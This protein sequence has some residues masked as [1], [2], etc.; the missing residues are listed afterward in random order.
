[1][2]NRRRRERDRKSE[3]Q[4]SKGVQRL[5]TVVR[6]LLILV[7]VT[8]LAVSSGTIYPFAVGK[9]VYAHALI[10]MA[11]ACWLVLVLVAPT[12]RPRRAWVFAA[13]LVWLCVSVLAAY[14]G[15]SPSRSLWSTYNRMGG[16]VDLAHWC[17][18]AV[19]I[20]SVFRTREHWKQLLFAS[21]LVSAVVSAIGILAN[22]LPVVAAS[23]LIHES[24]LSSTLG[25]GLLIGAY[26]CLSAGLTVALWMLAPTR[27]NA[28]LFAPILILNLTALWL[29]ASRGGLLVFILMAAVFAVGCLILDRRHT[30]RWAAL[31][32]V[33]TLGVSVTAIA[34][35]VA[36]APPGVMDKTPVA[37]QRLDAMTSAD[38][39]SINRR[40][41]ATTAALQAYMEHPVLGIG[42][43]NFEVAWGRH[44]QLDWDTSKIFDD[45]HSVFLEVL[46]TTGTLG[47][48]A[49]VAL[50][51]LLIRAA[52]R[53]LRD[54]EGNERL[55]AL[56]MGTILIGYLALSVSMIGATTFAL[57]FAILLGYLAWDESRHHPPLWSLPRAH[58][59]VV[60]I[61]VGVLTPILLYATIQ[62]N[63]GILA[64]AQTPMRGNVD[65]VIA[66]EQ[67]LV[68]YFPPMA[69]SRRAYIN[70]DII[71]TLSPNSPDHWVDMYAPVFAEHVAD[72]ISREP[73]N[74]FWPHVAAKTYQQWSEHDPAYL[75][76]A[77]YYLA[78]LERLSP[79]SSYTNLVRERQ[80]ILEEAK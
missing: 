54:R 69:S 60:L 64:S 75:D 66:Y 42:P 47:A 61:A 8:P 59:F 71:E 34:L 57:Y 16:L 41:H 56:A 48:I 37:I 25:H 14:H 40:D 20:A 10:Q 74:W 52:I 77:R 3:P 26:T 28:I 45:A 53:S 76:K 15:A 39:G 19:M 31:G 30:V 79:D 50:L 67:S 1:M 65:Q 5:A 80:A 73:E 29:S 6:V 44:A 32:A 55:F 35:L 21:V 27:R 17:V 58:T 38:D 7:C 72:A 12:E 49:Y 33:L 51:V 36:F 11:A 78:E 22:V 46:A 68:E 43:G 23:P 13:L 62:Y 18:Y 4:Q 24:R 9:A 2:A 63:I 70:P